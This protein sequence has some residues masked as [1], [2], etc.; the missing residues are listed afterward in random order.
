MAGAVERWAYSFEAFTT[1]QT[2]VSSNMMDR[3][4]DGDHNIILILGTTNTSGI[5]TVKALGEIHVAGDFS[6]LWTVHNSFWKY[7]RL[8]LSFETSI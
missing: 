6:V 2:M 4:R 7:D 1:L 3:T 8:I 5:I